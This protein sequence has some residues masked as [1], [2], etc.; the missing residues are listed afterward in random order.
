LVFW[1]IQKSQLAINPI[2]SLHVS[3]SS[4][5]RTIPVALNYGCPVKY[6]KNRWIG[7]G[8]ASKGNPGS[9]LL[10]LRNSNL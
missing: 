7:A 10:A 5:A 6:P 3:F 2:G 8:S 1:T 4:A 9:P